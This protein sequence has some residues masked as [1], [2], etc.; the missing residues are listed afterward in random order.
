MDFN[1]SKGPKE[2]V[3]ASKRGYLNLIAN[4][5]ITNIVSQHFWYSIDSET[6]CSCTKLFYNPFKPPLKNPHKMFDAVYFIVWFKWVEF[7]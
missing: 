1:Q 5:C 3:L 2:C 4:V 7:I 6:L